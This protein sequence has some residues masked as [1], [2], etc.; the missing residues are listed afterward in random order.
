MLKQRSL[1]PFP[2]GRPLLQEALGTQVQRQVPAKVNSELPQLQVAPL[3][4]PWQGICTRLCNV[5][6]MLVSAPDQAGV[7][8]LE[9]TKHL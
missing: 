9:Q 2:G 8:S 6:D 4:K 5:E 3:L 1:T 7:C